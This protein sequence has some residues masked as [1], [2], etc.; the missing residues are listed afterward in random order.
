MASVNPLYN[1][2]LQGTLNLNAQAL[3]NTTEAKIYKIKNI[4]ANNK[5]LDASDIGRFLFFSGDRVLTINA[6]IEGITEGDSFLVGTN[7]N[8]GVVHLTP[9]SGV[10]LRQGVEYLWRSPNQVQLIYIG[11]NIWLACNTN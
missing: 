2:K 1:V 3:L 8:L 10:G 4:G 7:S 9:G 11:N 5:T 6:S